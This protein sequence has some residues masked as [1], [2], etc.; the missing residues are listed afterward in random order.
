MGFGREKR[1]SGFD[2]QVCS[3]EKEIRSDSEGNSDVLTRKNSILRGWG[4]WKMW[5]DQEK[6]C[7]PLKIPNLEVPTTLKIPLHVCFF[8]NRK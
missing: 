2:N 4:Y 7:A 8:L 3:L 5:A 1:E 6:R